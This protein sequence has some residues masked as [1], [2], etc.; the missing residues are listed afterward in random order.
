[1]PDSGIAGLRRKGQMSYFAQAMRS[2]P[3]PDYLCKVFKTGSLGLD[4][5]RRFLAIL[6][7]KK[8]GALA[9]LFI[10]SDLRVSAASRVVVEKR[11]RF[12]PQPAKLAGDP[13]FARLGTRARGNCL[14]ARLRKLR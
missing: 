10:S 12:L 13:G 2:T 3:S 5:A 11:S 7:I 14:G 8:P 1:M 9:G 4:F 6:E